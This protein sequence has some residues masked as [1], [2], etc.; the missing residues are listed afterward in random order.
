M[1]GTDTPTSSRTQPP[2][3]SGRSGPPTVAFVATGLQGDHFHRDYRGPGP[4]TNPSSRGSGPRPS[5]WRSR[6]KVPAVR[7]GRRSPHAAGI[8][9][10]PEKDSR[11]NLRESARQVGG[12]WCGEVV[13][14]GTVGATPAI[15][16]RSRGIARDLPSLRAAAPTSGRRCQ[17]SVRYLVMDVYQLYERAWSEIRKLVPIHYD[18]CIQPDGGESSE[19]G[20]FQDNG[21]DPAIIILCTNGGFER[22]MPHRPS[23]RLA[24]GV[25]ATDERLLAELITLAHEYGHVVSKRGQ[26]PTDE[27]RRYREAED[28]RR[29]RYPITKHD[30]DLIVA[31]ESLAWAVGREL[32]TGL[33]FKDWTEYERR[34]AVGIASYA[35]YPVA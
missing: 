33:G 6:P 14:S 23:R 29:L 22:K 8:A 24:S 18:T 17:L 31:E 21:T 1:P 15:C 35:Q 12:L 10:V 20:Y 16:R 3:A 19:G 5:F 34:E 28:R 25:D 32:L 27:W 13:N 9:D 7:T 26:T 11:A 2:H 4:S 30:R